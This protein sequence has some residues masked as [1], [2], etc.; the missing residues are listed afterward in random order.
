MFEAEIVT[1]VVKSTMFVFTVNVAVLDPA[2]M[3]ALPLDGTL[4]TDGSRQ[5]PPPCSGH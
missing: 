3:V 4:A 5:R 2:G 1:E